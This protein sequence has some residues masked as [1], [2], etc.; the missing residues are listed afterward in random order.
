MA[1]K[2][3]EAAD[4]EIME[5]E[6]VLLCMK[7]GIPS[8]VVSAK[9]AQILE[10]AYMTLDG[11]LTQAG[12]DEAAQCVRAF[13]LK[14]RIANA[15]KTISSTASSNEEVIEAV[16]TVSSIMRDVTGGVKSSDPLR[17]CDTAGGPT[18]GYVRQEADEGIREMSHLASMMT[19]SKG[20]VN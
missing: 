9:A 8:P 15:L 16:Y 6:I 2:K 11:K 1:Y 14:F 3:I 19:R 7:I 10:A 12:H 5:A 13:N 17:G 4:Y 18:S 20:R